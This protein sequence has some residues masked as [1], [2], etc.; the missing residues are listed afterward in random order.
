MNGLLNKAMCATSRGSRLVLVTQ[1]VKKNRK[2]SLASYSC[3]YDVKM[4]SYRLQ[5]VAKI[6]MEK[7]GVESKAFSFKFLKMAT[8]VK[9][10]K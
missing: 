4:P 8:P 1:L 7:K 5:I 10:E 9:K 3:F 2:L 6:D